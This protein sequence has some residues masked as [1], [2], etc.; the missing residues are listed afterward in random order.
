M[1]S[2]I[3]LSI[4]IPV[5][6]DPEG[7]RDT[8]SSM[9][10]QE[11]APEYEVI[12]VD[13]DSTDSTPNVIEEFEQEYPDVVKGYSETKVQ[14]SYAARNT[15]IKHANGD[16]TAFIDA[17][18]TV[19]Q[20]WIAELYQIFSTSDV[21]YLGCNIEMYISDGDE[22]LWARYD[23][24]VG[25]PVRHYLQTKRF[26]PTCALAVSRSVFDEVGYFDESLISGG[27]K[28][29]GVR[30]SEAGYQLGYA[31]DLTVYHPT[32]NSLSDLVKKSTRIG[33]GQTQ[34]WQKYG[35]SSHP[36]SLSKFL[37]PSPLRL[38]SRQSDSVPLY[39]LYPIEYGLKLIQSM[40]SIKQ[41]AALLRSSVVG[42]D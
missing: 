28:E 34:L 10:D 12:V 27:D 8:L 33:K 19:D 25:L 39:L 42:T 9:T 13:N 2:N 4:I 18:V 7:L 32:R 36:L 5:Y 14:S 30:V 26:A 35:L 1:F 24:S 41:Y 31:D 11:G 37:P 22:T 6:N 40:E 29:F 16:I 38:Q 23:K 17:D 15:G 20:S 21:D 3:K